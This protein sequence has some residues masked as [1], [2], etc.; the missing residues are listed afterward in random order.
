M[1]HF[2][3]NILT[4]EVYLDLGPLY[5]VLLDY[6]AIINSKHS[7]LSLVRIILTTN[8]MANH[9]QAHSENF[10]LT[11]F[12]VSFQSNFQVK[13]LYIN[14]LLLSSRVG[15]RA[16]IYYMT[17]TICAVMLGIALVTTIKPGKASQDYT[18]PNATKIVVKDTLT[19]DTLLD[20][21]RLVELGIC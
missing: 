2:L 18:Q 7:L 8:D 3:C 1:S 10:K 6:S 13:V 17:T 14:E 9:D 21:I 11:I 20:L 16:I 19:S 12:F 15:L 5:S 4:F